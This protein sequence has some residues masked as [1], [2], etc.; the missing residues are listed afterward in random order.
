MASVRPKV[1]K[2][3][4]RDELR[5][6]RIIKYDYKEHSLTQRAQL[7]AVVKEAAKTADIAEAEIIVAG[8]LGLGDAENFKIVD[9]LAQ[10]LEGA[11]GASR[12]AVDAGWFSYAHQVGQTGK[13]VR[14]KLYIACG[15]SGAIQ[16]LVGMRSSKIIV[17]INKD[18]KA[19]IFNVAD[20]CIVGDVLEVVPAL[21]RE[22][23]KI[24]PTEQA[25]LAVMG[26]ELE[27][28]LA[29]SS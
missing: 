9:D 26:S 18:P 19:P 4:Q 16:H 27:S 25:E 12:G 24:R 6:G 7:L 23:E 20:Y 8:G 17:A 2:G 1:F 3:V 28:Q 13:T 22:I 14:P 10:V 21:T 29:L 11:V 15:I 5:M